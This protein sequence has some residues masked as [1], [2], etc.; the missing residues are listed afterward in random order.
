MKAVALTGNFGSGKTTVLK[1]VRSFRVPTIDS[2]RIV[3]SLYRKPLVK[4]KLEKLFG[5]SKR[6]D[7]AKTVFS[8]SSKRKKLES[9][10][11]PLVWREVKAKLASFKKKRK[12]FVVVDVPLLFETGWQSKFG[13]VIVV[14]CP[15]KTCLERLAK[16]GFSR[17]DA[18]LRLKAQLSQRKKIK[19]AH[20]IIDNGGSLAKTRKQV[21]Q[22]LALLKEK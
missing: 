16:N 13:S 20:F 5:T 9:L 12:L 7:L 15:K 8:S 1:F 18:L 6:K 22:L 3:A 21:G 10:L 19:R 17:K 2:D 4:K 14:K 11:H